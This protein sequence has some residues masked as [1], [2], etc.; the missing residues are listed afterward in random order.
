MS[1]A[2][3]N[4]RGWECCR[5]GRC[6][7]QGSALRCVASQH[8]LATA[9]EKEMISQK[10]Q[11]KGASFNRQ[12]GTVPSMKAPLALPLLGQ[13]SHDPGFPALVKDAGSFLHTPAKEQENPS[14][15]PGAP[16]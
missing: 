13:T 16:T 4:A 9:A 3:Y 15:E 12:Q 14:E 11:N 2:E 6:R 1:R 5:G 10:V 8:P 7:L